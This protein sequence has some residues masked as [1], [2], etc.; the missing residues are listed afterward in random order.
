MERTRLHIHILTRPEDELSSRLIALQ[1]EGGEGK[2][3]GFDL[4][5]EEPD[6]AALLEAIFQA[7]SVAVW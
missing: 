5:V 3:R 6:Y 4:T 2:V 1:E 7:D